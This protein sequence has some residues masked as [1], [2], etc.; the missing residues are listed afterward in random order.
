[1]LAQNI[2]EKQMP[3]NIRIILLRN[4]F[5]IA[6]ICCFLISIIS[7]C[8]AVS[9]IKKQSKKVSR[10]IMPDS[11]LRKKA[12]LL[13]ITSTNSFAGHPI[14]K[15]FQMIFFDSLKNQC[16]DVLLMFP[17]DDVYPSQLLKLPK[18]DS[19]QIDNFAL[20]DIGRNLGLNAV[21]LVKPIE[22]EAKEKEKGFW[23]LKDTHYFGIVQTEIEV[24]NTAT[25]AKLLHKAIDHEVEIGGAEFD[26]IK[27]NKITNIYELDDAAENIAEQG[28]NLVCEVIGK[29]AWQGY[30]VSVD[31]NK[32]VLS[33]GRESGLEAGEI[34]DVFQ[35][36]EIIKNKYG[37]QFLV[38][39]Q[40]VGEIRITSV[41]IEKSEAVFLKGTEIKAGYS[42]CPK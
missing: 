37:Q 8:S 14:E 20:A 12:A 31:N 35:N 11:H 10:V 6:V 30:V 9:G 32:I 38:P 36:S 39:G 13:P 25:G 42:V 15:M 29:Q 23:L 4:V 19:G 40:K 27:S 2:K 33:S 41:F 5:F 34:M 7:G 3:A 21:I 1:V 16:L 22:I 26:A 28:G 24:Y 17:G 18:L